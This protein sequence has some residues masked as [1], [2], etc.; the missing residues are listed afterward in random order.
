M[1]RKTFRIIYIDFTNETGVGLSRDPGAKVCAEIH[2]LEPYHLKII[3]AIPAELLTADGLVL[4]D[5]S[6]PLSVVGIYP[7]AIFLNRIET[8]G[9]K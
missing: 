8:G 2:R 5:W 3:Q 7:T 6:Q 4:P 9:S 1:N